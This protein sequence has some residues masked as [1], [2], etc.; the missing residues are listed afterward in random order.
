MKTYHKYIA[1]A[2]MAFSF[3]ACEQE[4]FTPAVHGDPDAVKINA[5]IGNLQTRVAYGTDG[6][7]T[8]EEDDQIRVVNTNRTGKNKSDALYQKTGDDWLPAVATNY[9]VWDGTGNNLLYASYPATASYTAFT[10]PTDQS[11]AAKLAAADWMTDDY[12][13]AKSNGEAHFTFEHRLAMVTVKITQWNTEFNDRDQTVTSASIFSKGT[14]L[15][16]AYDED[17]EATITASNALTG[18]TPQQN[19]DGTEFTAIVVPIAYTAMDNL[20]TFTVDGTSL[21]VNANN[22]TL[23]DGLKAGYHYTFSLEVGKKAASISS[24][25]VTPWSEKEIEGGVAEEV[26]TTPEET[27]E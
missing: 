5:T 24:V 2:A 10:L 9:L 7:T 12:E 22:S 21:T 26:E 15:T 11:D 14:Q 19:A 4:D 13:G 20:M 27:T 25:S 17:G 3:A 16:A 18:I 23:T 8:F 1:L 6:T